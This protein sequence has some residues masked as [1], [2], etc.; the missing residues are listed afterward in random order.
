MNSAE[1]EMK[2]GSEEDR[3]AIFSTIGQIF[4]KTTDVLEKLSKQELII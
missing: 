2:T 1:E 3:M 4:D